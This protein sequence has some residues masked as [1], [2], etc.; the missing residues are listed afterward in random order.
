MKQHKD[1]DKNDV[2]KGPEFRCIIC[3][4]WKNNMDYLISKKFYNVPYMYF[5]CSPECSVQAH[6]KF[7]AL[8]KN[9][10]TL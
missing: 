3:K 2:R 7:S 9:R 5:L 4:K 8:K 6:I 1:Y 10:I